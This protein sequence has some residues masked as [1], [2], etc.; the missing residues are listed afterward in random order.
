MH[1][2]AKHNSRKS[3]N[4]TANNT[5]TVNK[6]T[7]PPKSEATWR[8]SPATNHQSPIT[9]HPIT[10]QPPA[11]PHPP[12]QPSQPPHRLP[13]QPPHPVPS[14]CSPPGPAYYVHTCSGREKRGNIAALGNHTSPTQ[15]NVTGGGRGMMGGGGR[16]ARLRR[17]GRSGGREGGR[18][19][20]GM[21]WL[22]GL[23]G[24]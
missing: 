11:R 17:E 9:T 18:G 12:S 13:N 19:G 22:V 6:K 2:I 8:R 23:V 1:Q 10:N 21:G 15:T 14:F 20:D 5:Y 16:N 3:V 24:E 4:T 7:P